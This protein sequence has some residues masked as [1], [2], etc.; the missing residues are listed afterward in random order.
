M[1]D[2]T[3][4]GILGK[5]SSLIE[6]TV[7]CW[8]CGDEA[9]VSEFEQTVE[10][11]TDLIENDKQ[12]RHEYQPRLDEIESKIETAKRAR[13][14]VG[15]LEAKVSDLEATVEDRRQSLETKRELL[16]EV[17]AELDDLDERLAEQE[18]EQTAEVTDLQEQIE[19]VRVDLHSAQSEAD[20]LESSVSDLKGRLEERER[21]KE[22]ID[23]LTAEITTLTDRIQTLEQDLREGF[24]D[25]IS[26]LIEVLDY[27]RIER[28]RLDGGFD[29]IVAREVNSVVRQD[30]I[31]HLSESEREM[32]GLVLALAGYVAFGGS[33]LALPLLIDTLGAFDSERTAKL[34]SY[35]ADE[36]PFLLAALLPDSTAAVDAAPYQ[37]PIVKPTAQ[38]PT[39]D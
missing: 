38:D 18:S 22:E 29:L 32:V 33:D 2:S 14:H 1:L 37:C 15:D 21:K 3:Y 9:A 25:A 6:D 23:R 36:T 30:E 24:N 13:K 26:D 7:T 8:A 16:E 35:F 12:R 10:E 34:I 17:R 39:Q 11:L 27:E 19:G 20:R 5:E 31:T 28:I 4:T